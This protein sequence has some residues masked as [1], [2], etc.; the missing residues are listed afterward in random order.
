M[1]PATTTQFTNAA[2][3]Q[4]DV[5]RLRPDTTLREALRELVRARARHAIIE[6]EAGAFVGLVTDRDLRLA[7]PS[8]LQHPQGLEGQLILDGRRIVEIAIRR[9]VTATLDG[10]AAESARVMLT[11]GLGCLPILRDGQVHGILTLADFARVFAG[12]VRTTTDERVAA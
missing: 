4:V 11:R 3:M 7:L 5:V 6:D 9:P 1:Y 12:G 8:R 2:L 10:D